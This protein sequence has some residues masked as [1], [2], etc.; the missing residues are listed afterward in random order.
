M[1]TYLVTGAAGFIGANYLKYILAKHDDIRVVVLDALT[2]AGNL[3]TIA[4]DIDNERC[5]FVKGDIC[6][7]DL[8]DQL[9]A[10]YKFDYIVNFAAE[11]HVDRSIENPQLFLQT[12][13]LGTYVLPNNAKVVKFRFIVNKKRKL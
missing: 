11:S 6:D 7:R 4:S 5:F 3:G 8:A 12:N 10:E 13:I 1:K 2:Y 9:F